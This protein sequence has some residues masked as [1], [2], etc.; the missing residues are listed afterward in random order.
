MKDL[1]IRIAIWV[2]ACM[3]ADYIIPISVG[4]CWIMLFGVITY[5]IQNIIIRN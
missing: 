2:A 5:E 4:R 1:I 3:V